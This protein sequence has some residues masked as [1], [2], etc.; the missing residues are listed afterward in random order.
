MCEKKK[1]VSR[2]NVKKITKALFKAIPDSPSNFEVVFA[3]RYH[4]VNIFYCMRDKKFTKRSFVYFVK[5]TLTSIIDEY[6]NK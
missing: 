2:E 6:A 1:S 5:E 3:L 4:Q